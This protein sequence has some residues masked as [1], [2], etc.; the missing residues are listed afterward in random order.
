MSCEHYRTD[1]PAAERLWLERTGG[2]PIMATA[3]HAGH[4]MRRELAPLLAIDVASRSREEDPY[5]DYWARAVPTWLV[6][7]RSRFEVDLNRSRDESIYTEPEMAFGLHLWRK[8]LP[9]SAISRSL[10]EYDAFYAELADV[11]DTMLEHHRRLVVLDLHAYNFKRDGPDAPP[12][13]PD[14]NPEVNVG[15]GHLDRRRWGA[16]VDRFMA[17]LR[18]FDFLGRSLD[19]RENV[20]FRGRELSHWIATRYAGDVGVLSVE[21]KKFYMDEWTGVGRIQQI[22]AIRDA[23]QSTVPGLLRSLEAV[24]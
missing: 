22:Q 1:R 4:A 21:F 13:P 2:G 10:E 19:V 20:K 14:A 16:L 6:P 3:V 18:A 23:L 9:Q 7:T 12:A 15:T 11:L 17:D 5:T 8:A 24:P